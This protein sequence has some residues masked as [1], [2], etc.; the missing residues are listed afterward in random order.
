MQTVL[1]RLAERDPRARAVRA[2]RLVDHAPLRE[3]E[4]SGFIRTLSDR[5]G[6]R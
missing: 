3:L 5:Y 1:D 2:E 6:V 4:T